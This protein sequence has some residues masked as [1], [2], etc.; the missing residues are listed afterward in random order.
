MSED[1]ESQVT[2]GGKKKSN[3]HKATCKCPICKNMQMKKGG[4]MPTLRP[5]NFIGGKKANGHKANCKCPI[6]VNMKHQKA[7]KK[8]RRVTR[9]RTM[10]GGVKRDRNGNIIGQAN[11]NPD[12]EDN[13]DNQLPANNLQAQFD[14]AANNAENNAG[15]EVEDMDDAEDIVVEEDNDMVVEGD[16]IV[17]EEDDDMDKSVKKQRKE[18]GKKKRKGN[19]HKATC[20]CPICKNMKM[21]KGGALNDESSSDG[22]SSS[23]SDGD[24]SSDS[25]SNGGGKK[26]RKGNGHKAACKC[27]ICKNMKKGGVGPYTNVK[28]EEE[29]QNDDKDLEIGSDD[30]E[31]EKYQDER[32]RV[33]PR[34]PKPKSADGLPR[35]F[36]DNSGGSRRRRKTRKSRKTRKIRRRR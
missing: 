30:P 23:N 3:G 8:N 28:K 15:V 21:K 33:K 27:P 25:E 11:E 24:S 19:G 35:P 14:A 13:E 9:N 31:A 12:N 17:V 36:T 34:K 32:S 2:M 18:G 29:N 16:G 5:A 10:K 22:D 7:S 6:C 4:S 1:D 26:K 20:K